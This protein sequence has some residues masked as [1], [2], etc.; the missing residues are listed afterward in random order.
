[1]GPLV[2]GQSGPLP[3]DT[4]NLVYFRQACSRQVH[5]VWD[6][7]VEI[8]LYQLPKRREERGKAIRQVKG[9]IDQHWPRLR[10]DQFRAEGRLIGSGTVESGAKNV[11]AWRMKQGG[12]SW[13][14]PRAYRM[15]AAL[16]MVHS[17]RWDTTV[18][19]LAKAA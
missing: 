13:S 18:Q 14:R 16:G 12:Q 6:L 11:V 3:V 8:A 10:Y 9:Y 15:L 19:R 7:K 2:F 5:A 17:D 1:M 4:P